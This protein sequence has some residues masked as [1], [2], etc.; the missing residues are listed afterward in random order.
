M[1]GR[2]TDSNLKKALIQVLNPLDVPT[3]E[4]PVLFNPTEYS[5]DKQVNYA[6]QTLPGLGT[7]I[8]Q[9]V[10]GDAETLSMELFFDTYEEGTDVREHTDRID[11]LLEVDGDR[12]AP[13]V[14]RFVWGS[15]NFKSVLESASK[16]FTMFLPD[17]TP[18]R[19]RIDVTFREYRRPG[20]EVVAVPRQSADR[21]ETW[22]VTEGDTLWTIAA[23]QYGDPGRWRPI[24]TAND[25]ENPRR[26]DPGRELIVP[27]LEGTE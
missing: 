7:P 2:A 17:G 4:I 15:L 9:F 23:E 14:C 12:H 19:A 11:D 26:L 10:S 27:P 24:A 3:D 8:S 16:T 25:I 13:P 21:T 18:V 6:D 1:S 22:V 20:E 5:L